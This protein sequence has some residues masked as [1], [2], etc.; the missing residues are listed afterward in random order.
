MAPALILDAWGPVPVTT[1]PVP[2]WPLTEAYQLVR[3]YLCDAA[4]TDDTSSRI[5]AITPRRT[6]QNGA[7]ACCAGASSELGKLVEPFDRTEARGLQRRVKGALL[8][9]L[10]PSTPR[11]GI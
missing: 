5:N 9:P 7:Y 11:G 10:G 4:L 2:P 3:G 1:T 6:A 8:Q